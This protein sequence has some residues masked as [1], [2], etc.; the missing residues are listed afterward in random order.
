MTIDRPSE[1]NMAGQILKGAY[2]YIILWREQ[3]WMVNVLKACIK[4]LD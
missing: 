3:K 4:I 2:F 1:T